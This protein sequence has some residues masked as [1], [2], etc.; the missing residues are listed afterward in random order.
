MPEPRTEAPPGSE[1][2]PGDPSQD[3]ATG[4]DETWSMSP[5]QI[6]QI[7]SWLIAESEVVGASP[8][9]VADLLLQVLDGQPH[10]SV[11]IRTWMRTQIQAQE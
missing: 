2:S 6:S 1:E 5:E 10:L 3:S 7:T 8:D 11:P 4:A 9:R